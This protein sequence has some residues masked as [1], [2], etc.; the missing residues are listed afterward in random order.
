MRKFILNKTLDPKT[1]EMTGRLVQRDGDNVNT[2]YDDSV[3]EFIPKESKYT[4]E[5]R[6]HIDLCNKI[7]ESKNMDLLTENEIEYLL[8]PS[9]INRKLDDLEKQITDTETLQRMAGFKVEKKIVPL[10]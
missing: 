7:L 10:D 9:G 5:Q 6:E 1:F 2:I 8:D 3:E 4:K